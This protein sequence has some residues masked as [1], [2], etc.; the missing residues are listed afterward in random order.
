MQMNNHPNRKFF[1]KKLRNQSTRAE[2]YLWMYI[3]NRQVEGVKFRRQHSYGPY[4]MDFYCPA[5]RLC[6]EVDGAWHYTIEGMYKDQIRTEYLNNASIEV[7]R[8]ENRDVLMHIEG[9]LEA[10]KRHVKELKVK[11]RVTG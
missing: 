1:R 10:I 9:V 7:I 3:R 6:I 5:L 11:W 8:F 4:I 2:K